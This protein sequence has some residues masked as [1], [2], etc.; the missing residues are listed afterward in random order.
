MGLLY[1]PTGGRFLMSEASLKCGG[2]HLYKA[3]PVESAS[4]LRVVHSAI[5][6]RGD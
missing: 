5:S 6:C 1:G 3:L 4:R 2:V